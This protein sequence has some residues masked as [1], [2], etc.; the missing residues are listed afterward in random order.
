MIEYILSGRITY[1]DLFQ[2]VIISLMCLIVNLL[3]IAAFG[4]YLARRKNEK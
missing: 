1:G 2:T 4:I 3:I